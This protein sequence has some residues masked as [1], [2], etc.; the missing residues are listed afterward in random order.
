MVGMV[1]TERASEQASERDAIAG[2]SRVASSTHT[3]K[4]NAFSINKPW[5]QSMKKEAVS[6][7]ALQHDEQQQR[8]CLADLKLV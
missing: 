6:A 3:H 7:A 5:Q 4:H 2:Q 8:T 1:E